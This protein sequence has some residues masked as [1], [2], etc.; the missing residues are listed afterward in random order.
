M[1]TI[2]SQMHYQESYHEALK[3]RALG[4]RYAESCRQYVSY[5]FQ[6]NSHDR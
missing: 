6:L 3:I 1:V 2:A 4:P 5:G